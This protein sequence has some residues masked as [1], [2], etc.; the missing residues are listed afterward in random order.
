MPK[1]ISKSAF[2]ITISV[3]SKENIIKNYGYNSNDILVVKMPPPRLQMQKYT[4][5][6]SKLT[7]KLDKFMLFVGT[8]EPRK[9]ILNLLK[10]YVNL[11]K[12]I[13]DEFS[14]VIVGK[15]GW[16]F[17]PI[18]D[19]VAALKKQGYQ[20]NYLDYV[21]DKDRSILY[22]TAS[23]LIL[24]SHYEG[25]GMPILEAFSYDLPCAVSD[26]NIFHEVAGE[27]AEYFNQDDPND[28]ARVISKLL[29]NPSR[30]KAL[31]GLGQEK[32]EAYKI[33][34]ST[35]QLVNKITDVIGATN[36]NRN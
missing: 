14:L 15:R 9:N 29:K 18:I 17:E 27:A 21:T 16:N 22:S 3:N 30:L 32:I 24:P 11:P 5:E 25:F 26:I 35:L 8:I 1:T 10:S 7:K 6:D 13:R 34:E 12:D 23:L 19:R 28:M 33:G 20:I 36:D 2:V 31:K 4:R